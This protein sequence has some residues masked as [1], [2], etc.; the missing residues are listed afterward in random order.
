LRRTFDELHRLRGEAD[1]CRDEGHTRDPIPTV[2]WW[3]GWR[4][5][6]KRWR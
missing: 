5:P 6:V 1:R 2:P 4:F 3:Q